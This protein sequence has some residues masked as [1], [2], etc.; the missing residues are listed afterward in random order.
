[1]VSAKVDMDSTWFWQSSTCPR[2]KHFQNE[3]PWLCETP[4]LIES[5]TG[6]AAA[7]GAAKVLWSWYNHSSIEAAW[8]DAAA[9]R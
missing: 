6:L 4:S 9:L 2:Q 7:C 1:M 5:V 3:K 8:F